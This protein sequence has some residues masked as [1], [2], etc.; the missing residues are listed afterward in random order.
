M[1]DETAVLDIFAHEFDQDEMDTL[2]GIMHD[3]RFW[4]WERTSLPDGG[5]RIISKAFADIDDNADKLDELVAAFRD[6]FAP[7]EIDMSKRDS[8]TSQ[9]PD[10]PTSFVYIIDIEK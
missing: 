8:D 3:H 7:E 1:P 4:F 9:S 5:T 6:E 10:V 2:I